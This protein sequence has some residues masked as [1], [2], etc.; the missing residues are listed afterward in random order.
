LER[1]ESRG[2]HYREDYPVQNDKDWLKWL[3][4]KE[5]NGKMVITKEAIPIDK[6]KNKPSEGG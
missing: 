2:N 1:T 5:T 6:Y 3:V 4:V